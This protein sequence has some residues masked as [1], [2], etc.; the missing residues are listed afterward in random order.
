MKTRRLVFSSV[1]ISIALCLYIIEMYIQLPFTF[2]GAKIGLANIVTVISL[3]ILT[4]YET[5]LIV[6]IRVVLGSIFSG[7]LS[8]FL[9]SVSG[10]ILSFIMMLTLLK[11]SKNISPV[12]ISM[13]GGIFHNVGQVLV[14]MFILN[15]INIFWYL[16]FLLV[17]GLVTGIFIGYAA[18]FSIEHLR[19]IQFKI[20]R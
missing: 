3:Y 9:F 4:P 11:I 17:T 18:N 19:R 12:G 5:F 6:I 2:P 7:N 13:V 15:N 14:A 16:P 10:A 1:L 20:E 8:S